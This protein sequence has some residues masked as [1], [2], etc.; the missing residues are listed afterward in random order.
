MNYNSQILLS[1]LSNSEISKKYADIIN[2]KRS[3]K[4]YFI[5]T[6]ANI[7]F[8]IGLYSLVYTIR[9]GLG[10][11]GLNSNVSWGLSIINFVFWIGIAHS[12]TLI[13]A[14]LYL[15]NQKWRNSLNR[16]AET[17]TLISLLC[18]AIFPIIHTGRP[19]FAAYWL[20]PY[21]NQMGIWPNFSSPLV[22]DFFAILT[23]FIISLIFWYVGLIPDFATLRSKIK[24]NSLKNVYIFLSLGWVG[25]YNQWENYKKL[26][27]VLAG[28]ATPLVISV[29]TIVSLDFAVTLNPGWH[30]TIFPIYFVAGAMFSGTAMVTILVIILRN[31]YNLE[32]FITSLHFNNLGKLILTTCIIVT[33]SYI[34]E[35]FNILFTG[36][37]LEILLIS[38]KISE[39]YLLLFLSVILFN[40]IIPQLLWIKRIRCNQI[41]ML[42]ISCI[43]VIGMWLERYLIVIPSIEKDFVTDNILYYFPTWIEISIFL[44]TIGLFITLFLI[45]IKYLPIVSLFEVKML[46]KN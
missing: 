11:F 18:A 32:Y 16:S 41:F 28:L 42:I 6:V 14:I 30:S 37:E 5:L 4:Y 39:R 2:S 27:L 46:N 20:I 15:F 24:S 1:K 17:M 31:I 38:E 12:G 33:F 29:H 23:Y 45:F 13:S 43:I 36:N 19:W 22:W 9:E 8:I 25:S 44:G 7:L 40:F 21:P 10:V 26:Y 35:L 3:K 34:M